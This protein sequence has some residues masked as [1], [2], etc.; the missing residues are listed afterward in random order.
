LEA[1][2]AQAA[3]STKADAHRASAKGYLRR[4]ARLLGVPL[5]RGA[6][7]W[8]NPQFTLEASKFASSPTGKCLLVDPYGDVWVRG[9]WH[10]WSA[11][12]TEYCLTR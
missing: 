9:A 5:V 11:G 12:W 1:L 6:R 7:P 8:G 2:A 10:P 4:A 3:L